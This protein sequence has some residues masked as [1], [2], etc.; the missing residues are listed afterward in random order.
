MKKKV[1]LV[2][3][4]IIAMMT[5]VIATNSNE[6]VKNE[7]TLISEEGQI[8]GITEN[9]FRVMELRQNEILI[10][11]ENGNLNLGETLKRQEMVVLISRLMGKEEEAKNWDTSNLTFMDVSKENWAAGYIAWAKDNNITKG[12]SEEWFGYDDTLTGT[13]TGIF[14]LRVLGYNEAEMDNATEIASRIG[15]IGYYEELQEGEIIRG[16]VALMLYNTLYCNIKNSE[17]ILSEKLNVKSVYKENEREIA[18]LMSEKGMT[19]NYMTESNGWK[20][21]YV[22]LNNKEINEKTIKEELSLYTLIGNYVDY[23]H[24]VLIDVAT[25]KKVEVVNYTEQGIIY[26]IKIDDKV[27]YNYNE[28]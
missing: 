4:A 12:Y 21:M 24:Y 20:I 13:Q 25:G 14:L 28:Q 15:I 26:E 3:V 11:D 19:Y 9:D 22:D 18:V 2:I 16:E 27:V 6:I 7:G 8:R 17:E 10:G 23:S 5:V 1:L